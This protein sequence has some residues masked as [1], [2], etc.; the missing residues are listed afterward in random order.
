MIMPKADGTKEI[1]TVP[2]ENER[3]DKHE[4]YT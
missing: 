1:Y 4:N 3:N 2:T